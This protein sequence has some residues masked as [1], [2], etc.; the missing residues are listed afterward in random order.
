[1]NVSGLS[2]TSNGKDPCP[3]LTEKEFVKII[4]NSS[5]DQSILKEIKPE[6]SLEG[7]YAEAEAHPMRRANSLGKD[8]DAGK[9]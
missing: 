8:R 4:A 9:D 2:V 1:M 6:Y 3:N 7:L 5:L